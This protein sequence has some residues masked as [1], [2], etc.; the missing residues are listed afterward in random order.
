MEGVG[1]EEDG[2][3]TYL[4]IPSYFPTIVTLVRTGFNIAI[5]SDP[6][7]FRVLLGKGP[8]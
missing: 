1:E 3:E 8:K 5:D 2:R 7:F 6:G 4:P